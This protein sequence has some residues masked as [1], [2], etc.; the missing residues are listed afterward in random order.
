MRKITIV[1]LALV[2]LGILPVL[3]QQ[4]V[5]EN[6][7]E[8]FTGTND[9]LG[10][11]RDDFSSYAYD[12]QYY[13]KSNLSSTLKPAE[14]ESESAINNS[15]GVLNLPDPVF[16]GNNVT[17]DV[18]Q[19]SIF[20]NFE[21]NPALQA[22]FTSNEINRQITLSA[23][24]G[25]LGVNAQSRLQTK[26]ND[27]QT[28]L[29]RVDQFVEN[30]KTNQ[31]NF[32]SQILQKACSV[33]STDP[34]S[35]I[36]A[37]CGNAIQSNLQA[38]G[39]IIQGGQAKIMG[40]T[41][42]S[43]ALLNQSLQYSNLNLASISQQ[44]EETNRARRVDASVEAA[45]LLRATSQVDLLGRDQQSGVTNQPKPTNQPGVQTPSS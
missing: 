19:K 2:F 45:R 6:F 42:A 10:K 26:F 38:Q 12:L 20:S 33:A 13:L 4:I 27:V 1:T 35:P 22:N 18:T 36:T 23:V 17:V 14:Y 30:V 29:E 44:M 9:Q 8:T 28:F 24:E 5:P 39:L 11:V 25:V 40:E 34:T 7:T 37:P 16:A 32:L 3:A 43:T 15:L 41:L 21:N 31:D